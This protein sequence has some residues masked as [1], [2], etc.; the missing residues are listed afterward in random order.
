MNPLPDSSVDAS[1]VVLIPVYND[2]EALALVVDAL[3]QS[4]ATLDWQVRVLIVDDGSDQGDPPDVLSSPRLS[5]V[6]VDVLALRRNLGH[7]RA[8]AIGLAW[9]EANLS[10]T[11]VVVMDGDGEDAPSDVPRLVA[12]FEEA[13]RAKVIFA[14]RRRRSEGL[15][16]QIFYQ[17]YR[18]VHR[19]L[20]G[21]PVRVG[22]FSLLP[23]PVV[24]RLVVVSDLW[25][26][27]AAAVF[28]ARL[29][30]TT[31]PTRRA[32][33]LMGRPTMNFTALV[34]HGLSAISVLGDRVGVRLLIAAGVLFIISLILFAGLA[35]TGM[36]GTAELSP[37]LFAV[38]TLILLVAAQLIL[39]VTLF[40]FGVL[41]RRDTA[42]FLP[43]RDYRYFVYGLTN[44]WRRDAG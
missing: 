27:Y 22:N 14:A 41:G 33:R 34:M 19:I 36:A 30:M 8:I 21:I 25:N 39:G 20:T 31:I 12:Q 28:K 13:G 42:S 18:F 35:G 29:P 16:F 3:D 32:H 43:L 38:V 2:W 5:I 15:T 10:C 26:H 7:Q 1:L 44:L 17:L 24:R 4:V 9:L 6:S 23:W 37:E 11:A 40:L